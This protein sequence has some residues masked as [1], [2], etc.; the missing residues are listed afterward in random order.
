[1]CPSPLPPVPCSQTLYS[2][3]PVAM[4]G[5]V[6]VVGLISVFIWNIIGFV[7]NLNVARSTGLSYVCMPVYE[8]TPLWRLSKPFHQAIISFLFPSWLLQRWPN[9][10]FWYDDWRFSAR[11]SAHA[12][13]GDVFLIVSPGGVLVEV[14]DAQTVAYVLS[15]GQGAFVK[16]AWIYG[17]CP[18]SGPRRRVPAEPGLMGWDTPTQTGR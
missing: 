17:R 9:V 15:K 5:A 3:K 14:A 7:R 10:V 13:L 2:V 11:H 6:G 8:P 4:L 16:P 1:M 18:A 12:R